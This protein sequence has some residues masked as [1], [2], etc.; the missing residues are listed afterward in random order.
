MVRRSWLPIFIACGLGFSAPLAVGHEAHFDD[1]H[2]K[3]VREFAESELRA[4]ASAAICIEAV[5][6]QNRRHAN[7]TQR[8][9]DA[10]D[11]QWRL[12]TVRDDRPLIASIMTK[13]L[14]FYLAQLKKKMKG[15]V[16]EI[17][18]MDGKG[19]NV[20]ASDVDSDYWQ[21]DEAKWQRT[22]LVGPGA[23]FVDDVELDTSTDL[24]QSEISMAITD[25]DTG[26][27]I[28]AIAV[29]IDLDRLAANARLAAK[30]Q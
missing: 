12:E 4:W 19:L 22:F 1:V 8:Q 6:A 9:I 30:A 14:S 26:E 20:A 24:F 11:I 25:A 18:V 17:V 13:R 7:I 21:G 16:T 3:P 10:L 5:R 15:A 28:G 2:L 23:V 29:G 27:V